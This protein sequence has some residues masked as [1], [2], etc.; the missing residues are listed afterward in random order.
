MI[1]YSQAWFLLIK[2][3][4]DF[5]FWQLFNC[6]NLVA[7]RRRGDTYYLQNTLLHREA[8][9]WSPKGCDISC[10]KYMNTQD[11]TTWTLLNGYFQQMIGSSYQNPV[12]K[13]QHSLRWIQPKSSSRCHC[14]ERETGR[15]RP[16]GRVGKQC[17]Y[18]VHLHAALP[19][20]DCILLQ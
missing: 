16:V 1:N 8:A 9:G 3:S 19:S 12:L 20:I 13:S 10:G 5:V 11:S 17:G 15:P 14:E 2:R 7:S 4:K 18:K 6:S